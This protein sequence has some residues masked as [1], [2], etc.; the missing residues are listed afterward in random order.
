MVHH[1]L[2]LTGFPFSTAHG[3]SVVEMVCVF[4]G[5]KKVGLLFEKCSVI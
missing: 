4:Y 1:Y 2:H 3:Q 5:E